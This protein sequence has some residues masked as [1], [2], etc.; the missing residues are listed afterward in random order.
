MEILFSDLILICCGPLCL[1]DVL[2]PG[3]RNSLRLGRTCRHRPLKR[4]GPVEAGVWGLR[5][6]PGHGLAS[7]QARLC[8]NPA[9]AISVSAT[10]ASWDPRQLSEASG[11][12]TLNYDCSDCCWALPL[13]VACCTHDQVYLGSLSEQFWSTG[14]I[15]R[16]TAPG[17]W[18]Q[19]WLVLAPC[20][21]QSS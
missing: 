1:P 9:A 17:S 5:E 15:W 11:G 13:P 7:D 21:A 20:R 2:W 8:T 4:L 16:L 19:E 12:V 10:L 18:R 6:A 3:L 14:M